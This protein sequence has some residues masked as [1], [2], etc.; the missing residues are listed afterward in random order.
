MTDE[1]PSPLPEVL[2]LGLHRV[3]VPEGAR[4]DRHGQD[5]AVFVCTL[6][7]GLR[8]EHC[9]WGRRGAREICRDCAKDGLP[10]PIAWERRDQLGVMPAFGRSVVELLF[11]PVLF[12]RTP[13]LEDDAVGGFEHGLASF[14]VGQ[15]A[16]FLQGLF[17]F[18]LFGSVIAAAAH[19][20]ALAAFFGGYGCFMLAMIP[21][22]LA[23]VP[24]TTMLAV[25]TSAVCMHLTLR[26]FGAARA[27]FF[28]GTVR[29]TSYAFASHVMFVIPVVGPLVALV[30]TIFLETIGI[31]E[32][33]RC[34]TILALVAVLAYRFAL[35]AI[36]VGL[37]ALIFAL[38]MAA[39]H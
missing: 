38:A 16:V 34:G 6:C 26:L 24:M 9:L 37:Y 17:T 20:P 33:H 35:L 7:K 8:C 14:A 27:P 19:V 36:F 22:V 12:F 25:G 15:L 21:A 4:C 3:P 29:A 5:A 1:S 2:D 28:A 18:A 11:S 10:E 31:R 32:V 13:A 39:P 23:H 30:W